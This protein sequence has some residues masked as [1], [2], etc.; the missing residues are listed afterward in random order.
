MLWTWWTYCHITKFKIHKF[1]VC[2]EVVSQKNQ[3]IVLQVSENET[4][5]HHRQQ[6]VAN[7]G[8]LCNFEQQDSSRTKSRTLFIKDV[9]NAV[10]LSI[11]NEILSQLS[12]K[13]PLQISIKNST[14]S[15]SAGTTV[16]EC[17]STSFEYVL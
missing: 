3:I 8:Q 14:S 10:R 7:F 1:S 11:F 17:R 13:Y 9:Q 5:S 12:A 6:G 15:P 4:L 2:G 16:F